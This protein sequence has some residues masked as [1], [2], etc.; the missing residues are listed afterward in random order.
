MGILSRKED[1]ISTEYDNELIVL[2]FEDG[3]YYGLEGA[4]MIL[5]QELEHGPKKTE[6][7]LNLWIEKYKNNTEETKALL[8]SSIEILKE[9]NLLVGVS[10]D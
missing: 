1:T 6:D 8:E 4:S 5:W 10:T 7:I 9:Y 2:D 3:Q